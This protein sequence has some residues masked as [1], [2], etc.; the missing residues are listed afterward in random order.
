MP[1]MRAALPWQSP[2]I[3]CLPTVVCAFVHFRHRAAHMPD[4][5]H[6]KGRCPPPRMTLCVC[7]QTLPGYPLPS[8]DWPLTARLG[9]DGRAPSARAL[10]CQGQARRPDTPRQ[11]A[12]H[13]SAAC[14]P[15]TRAPV[16]LARAARFWAVVKLTIVRSLPDLHV[17]LCSG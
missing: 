15:G 16:C 17:N 9:R 12:G 10:S 6:Q 1:P 5:S 13:R 14:D 3:S 4:R 11:R 2:W 7:P 8:G